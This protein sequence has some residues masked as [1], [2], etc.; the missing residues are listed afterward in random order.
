MPE[1][2]FRS[3]SR[4]SRAEHNGGHEK[5]G[6]RNAGPRITRMDA[7]DSDVRES[8]QTPC[9]VS[10]TFL[11]ADKKAGKSSSGAAFPRLRSGRHERPGEVMALPQQGTKDAKGEPLAVT[12]AG[13]LCLFAASRKT[14]IP[15]P[16]AIRF[17]CFGI[18]SNLGFRA[19]DFAEQSAPASGTVT[20]LQPAA[21][22]SRA[23]TN[24]AVY[25]P[26]E[27]GRWRAA[28]R[29]AAWR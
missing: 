25:S 13:I 5:T 8:G 14:A 15:F 17:S 29:P 16:T 28:K 27:S 22:S 9:G 20:W 3:Y 23:A 26:G 12:V 4:D 21:T 24:R 7:N 19:S 1:T 11:T 6:A 10:M 18:V 2:G